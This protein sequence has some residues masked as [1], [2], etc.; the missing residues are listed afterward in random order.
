MTPHRQRTEVS[1][2]F[3]SRLFGRTALAHALLRTLCHELNGCES[4]NAGS[5]S[6]LEH[7]MYF[8]FEKLDDYQVSVDFVVVADA[9]TDAFPRG[10]AYLKDQIRRAANSIPANIAEGVGEFAANDKARFYRIARRSAVE[11]ASHL[12][13]SQRLGLV[14]ETAIV[15]GRG[16]L[17]R[18]V[19]MLTAMAKR[20]AARRPTTKRQEIGNGNGNGNDNDN[21]NVIE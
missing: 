12:L 11:C 6:L 14:D 21:D 3:V 13:I 8:E 5:P 4:R 2:P 17:L 20:V 16:L 9:I 1:P 18:I 15:Q 7:R 10:R 19:A